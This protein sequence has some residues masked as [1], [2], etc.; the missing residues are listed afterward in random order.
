MQNLKLVVEKLLDTSKE[1]TDA[2][3]ELVA[4]NKYKKLFGMEIVYRQQNKQS[5]QPDN[6]I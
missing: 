1:T 5:I 2:L 4:L 3:D 6:R